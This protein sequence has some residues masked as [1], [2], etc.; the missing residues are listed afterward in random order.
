ML[1]VCFLGQGE[2]STP[3]DLDFWLEDLYMPGFDSLLKKK[4]AEGKRKRLCKVLASVIV[5]V[6]AVLVIVVPA[7]LLQRKN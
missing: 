1:H 2:E 6:C 7:V 4:E 3:K 5:S